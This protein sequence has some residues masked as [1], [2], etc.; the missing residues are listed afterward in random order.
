MTSSDSSSVS[1]LRRIVRE[2]IVNVGHSV[3]STVFWTL[4]S[5]FVLLFGVQLLQFGY[6]ATGLGA[7][8][9]ILGGTL[10]IG[11]SLYLLYL[12]YR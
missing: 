6:V 4:V 7:V 8:S 12:L 5:V 3:L 9:M 10:M 11:S 2:E 1:E